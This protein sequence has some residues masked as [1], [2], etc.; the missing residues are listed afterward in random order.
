MKLVISAA[1]LGLAAASQVEMKLNA[2]GADSDECAGCDVA[3]PNVFTCTNPPCDSEVCGR[4]AVNADDCE[5][6]SCA[7][8]CSLAEG[9][10][11]DN[12]NCRGYC[13]CSG[14]VD[15]GTGTRVPSRWELCPAGTF[16]DA[17]CKGHHNEL[18][19]GMGYKGGCCN[20]AAEV[21]NFQDGCDGGCERLSKYFCAKSRTCSWDSGC[22]CCRPGKPEEPKEPELPPAQKACKGKG[23]DV[24]FIVDGSGSIGPVNFQASKDFLKKIASNFDMGNTRVSVVQYSVSHTIEM[25]NVIDHDE[26]M[27]K[28]DAIPYQGKSTRTGKACHF[29]A[30]NQQRRNVPGAIMVLTDGVSYDK[31]ENDVSIRGPELHPSN[32]VLAVGVGRADTTQL[33]HIAS[34]PDADNVYNNKDWGYLEGIADEI[35]EKLCMST[36][37]IQNMHG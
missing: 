37:G 2:M 33:N 31:A 7:V 11:R 4:M 18:A 17:D 22:D 30:Q 29:W 35:A 15:E 26:L 14:G 12:S 5:G 3:P 6:D 8:D 34:A 21:I 27:S 25:Q 36:V 10:Y 20:H 32:L 16:Y 23:L 28:I 19:N 1:V 13:F 24:A 9:Y